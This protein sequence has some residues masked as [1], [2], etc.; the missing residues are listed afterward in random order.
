MKSLAQQFAGVGI[1]SLLLLSVIVHG[2]AVADVPGDHPRYLHARSDL[3][4]ADTLLNAPGSYN[5]I[6]EMWLADNQIDAAIAEI[7]R[8]SV[9]DRKD[10][11]DHPTVDTSLNRT[12]RLHRVEQLLQ[13]AQHDL[14]QAED[15]RHAARWRNRAEY[16]IREAVRLIDRALSYNG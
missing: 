7:D 15:N 1:S 4:R 5:V 16:H 11:D 3:R 9:L 14:S 13:S 10:L 8:A 6:R 12:N 2:K